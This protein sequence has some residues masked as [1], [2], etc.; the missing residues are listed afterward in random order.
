MQEQRLDDLPVKEIFPGYRGRFV[1]SDGMT[2]VYWDIDAG[3][4]VPEHAHVHEQVVNVLA[5]EFE[6]T[7]AGEA[8]RLGPGSVVVIPGNVPHAARAV[9]DCRVIDVF[10]PVREEYR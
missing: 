6:L 10:H 8:R 7:V 9:T 5:G 1:H 2:I 3:A 4:P